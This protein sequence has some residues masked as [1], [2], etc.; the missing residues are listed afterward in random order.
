MVKQD[1]LHGFD[2]GFDIVLVLTKNST[3][4]V[5]QTYKRMRKEFSEGIKNNEV[6]VHDIMNMPKRFSKYELNS[7]KMIIIAKKQTTN[8]DRVIRFICNQKN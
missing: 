8:L 1:R 2:N 4:L 3:A 7:K 6:D 5:R